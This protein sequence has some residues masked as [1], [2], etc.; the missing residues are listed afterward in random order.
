MKTLALS[1]TASAALLCFGA[2]VLAQGAPPADAKKEEKKK[3][4]KK[5]DGAGQPA[6][7]DAPKK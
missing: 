4:E 7:S 5:K 3:E 1:L 6:P 2:N